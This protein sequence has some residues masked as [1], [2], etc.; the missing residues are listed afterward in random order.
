[1]RAILTFHNVDR[2]GS[3]LSID[4][5]ALRSLV[6]A[7]RASGHEIAA[8][9][10]LLG[11]PSGA[12]RVALTFDDGLAGLHEH[13]APVLAEESAPAT[14]FVTTD[15]V[16]KDNRWPTLPPAA[17]TIAMMSWEQLAELRD[18]GWAIEAHTATHPDLR[19][20]SDDEIDAELA[21]CDEALASRLGLQP[22][23]FAY[24]Y[25]Y[26]DDRVEARVR[27]RYD[28]SVTAEMGR[29]PDR[30]ARAH[31]VGR[32]ETYY[33]RDP[34]IHRWFGTWEF[35]AYLA[36]RALLRRLRHG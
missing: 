14:V 17:P 21:R 32:L 8:L 4:P 31:R 34:R 2:S 29:V 9:A 33:F 13:A 12:D 25:G 1:M 23:L 27:P 3:V 10:D 20:L 5:A 7:I 15:F 19:K 35:D 22:R 36:G 30:I 11:D 18:A 26:V 28:F 24:P 16:G 6:R